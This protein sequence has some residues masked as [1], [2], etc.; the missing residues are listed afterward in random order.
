MKSI[1]EL[2]QVMATDVLVIGGGVSGVLAAIKAKEKPVDVLVVE[3]GGVGWAGQVP[4]TGGSCQC[5]RPEDAENWF[6]WNVAVGDYLN[7]QDWAYTFA[8][9]IYKCVVEAAGFGVPFLKTDDGDVVIKHVYQNFS[10]V[11]YNPRKFMI[12]LRQTAVKKGVRIL[13]KVNMLDL[14]R[15]DGRV[16]G[17]VGFGL[18]DGKTYII[19]AKAIVIANGGCMFQGQR[20]F[21]H[22]CGEGVVMAYH[23][24]AQLMNAEFSSLFQH[25]FKYGDVFGRTAVYIFYENATGE[26]ITEK[27]FPELMAGLE[28]GKEVEDF[29][30]VNR[31]IVKEVEAGKAP[32]YFDFGKLT[33]E[34]R[35]V[36][37]RRKLTIPPDMQFALHGGDFLRFISEKS[38]LNLE[39]DKLEIIVVTA[40]G[41]GIIRVGLDCQTT[42][43]RLWAVGDASSVGCGWTGSTSWG[44]YPGRGMGFAILSGIRGG[45][46]AGEYAAATSGEVKVDRGEVKKVTERMLAPL[47]RRGTI[48]CHEVLYQIQ[49]AMLPVK[50]NLHREAGR[51]NEAIGIVDK[52]KQ[53]LARVG[54][55]DHH[56]LSRYHQAESMALVAEFV[57]KAA[58]M[59]E[60][61]RGNHWREDYP[62]RDDENWLKWVVIKEEE[63]R[64]TF[65]TEPVPLEKY[66]LK[67]S[68][69]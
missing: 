39:K 25:V 59:R 18:V 61:S 11:R 2:G 35:E 48:D 9:E 1:E 10:Q 50:Y 33:P 15:Q 22:N 68:V 19:K 37:L 23:A 64:A 63:G 36:V 31:A 38:E 29:S 66:R 5:H 17:A 53:K 65:F 47:S 34:E 8:T 4:I 43:D 52:A 3:K 30:R 41:G 67:P 14:L 69:G 57:L 24:G 32:I 54:A 51:L 20:M 46:S 56:E 21:T 42:V 45:R 62:N 7:D 6:K 26:R 58:L 55:N 13:D 27:H 49:G 40:S 12:K 28:S 16:V 60:E 44:T